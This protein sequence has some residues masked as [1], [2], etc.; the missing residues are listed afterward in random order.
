MIYLPPPWAAWIW[1]HLDSSSTLSGVQASP[2]LRSY[3]SMAQPIQSDQ[4]WEGNSLSWRRLLRV[5]SGRSMAINPKHQSASAKFSIFRADKP[6][7][8]TCC[9]LAQL[10]HSS[11]LLPAS[12]KH[13]NRGEICQRVVLCFI[14]RVSLCVTSPAIG[15]GTWISGCTT[16]T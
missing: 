15:R 4:L 7:C 11:E 3:S 16:K 8:L 10:V 12:I 13:Q 9:R 5:Q 2:N 6:P 14:K 1:L